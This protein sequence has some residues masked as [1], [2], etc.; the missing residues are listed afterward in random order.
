MRNSHGG[1]VRLVS[2]WYA[3]EGD[4][5][6]GMVETER[7][8]GV[9]AAGFGRPGMEPITELPGAGNSVGAHPDRG[10]ERQGDALPRRAIVAHRGRRPGP[11]SASP[12][13]PRNAHDRRGRSTHDR[14]KKLRQS[15]PGPAD[16]DLPLGPEQHD[17]PDG[18]SAAAANRPSP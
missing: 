15:G 2:L 6:H 8:L 4:P 11:S 3:E 16:A 1:G 13:N 10:R 5:S 7:G 18:P 14:A 17:T 12:R 9:D